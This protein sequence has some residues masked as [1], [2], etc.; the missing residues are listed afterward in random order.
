[1]NKTK[2]TKPETDAKSQVEH[3]FVCVK[4]LIV[5][6]IFG[7]ERKVRSG[8]APREIRVH[9]LSPPRPVADHIRDVAI[10]WIEPD[11][12]RVAPSIHDEIPATRLVKRGAEGCAGWIGIGEDDAAT[13]VEVDSRIAIG[14]RG[15]S[16]KKTNDCI[17]VEL[18][19][20]SRA[21]YAMGRRR[22]QSA[23]LANYQV[24]SCNL[25]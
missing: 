1:M 20:I 24:A 2:K 4:V 9:L 12:D 16:T 8:L 11:F 7:V 3:H 21:M 23:V 10:S 5:V 18:A 19:P 6:T 17:S 15:C 14:S 22:T 13:C 25:G